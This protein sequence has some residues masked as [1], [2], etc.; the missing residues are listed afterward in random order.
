MAHVL[1]LQNEFVREHSGV[2]AV[3]VLLHVALLVLL[4]LNLNLMP[5][6]QPRPVRLAIEATVVDAQAM[7][8]RQLEEER[9]E[10][11]VRQ[12]AER[13]RQQEQQ[14]QQRMEEARRAEE[15]RK[16]ARARQQEDQ[17]RKD[18]EA[19]RRDE[20]RRRQEAEQAR[21]AKLEQDR[22]QAEARKQ[23]A[24]EAARK[25]EAERRQAQIKSD[26]ARQLA[27]EENL[28]AA[29]D[30]GLLD[31]YAEII[32]QKVERNWIR[33]ASARSGLNCVVL[34]R[35]IPGG[36]VVEVKVT[37]CNGDAAVLRS[38]EAAVLR[39]SPLPPPPNPALFDRSLRFEFRPRD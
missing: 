37:E 12:A 26:L 14:R 10:Q 21:Q 33:P 24:A 11:A 9:R 5:R 38:I 20:A 16:Q 7:R 13:R 23:A 2:L 1:P 35:Q 39:S 3:S 19:K 30:A 15:A 8:R 34:V 4:A 28:A 18:A 25:A 36:D 17:R 32:R 22:R 6:Q 31:Q 27:E 29:A